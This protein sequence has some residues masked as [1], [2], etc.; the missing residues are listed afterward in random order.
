VALDDELFQRF[1][2]QRPLKLLTRVLSRRASAP[3]SIAR[4]LRYWAQMR[5]ERVHART[6][7]QTLADDYRMNELLGFSGKE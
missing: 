3:H 6:R 7:R 2:A 1:V 4:A 5:A